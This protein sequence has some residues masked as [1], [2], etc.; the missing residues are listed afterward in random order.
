MIVV[1]DVFQLKFGHAREAVEVWKEGIKLAQE[2]GYGAKDHRL[3]TDFVGGSYYTLVFETRFESLA[4]FEQAIQSTL[5][6][7]R[8]R[9]WYQKL[10]PHVDSGK[11][12]ILREV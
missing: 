12:E 11:R 10:L 4:E 1:R 9:E 5:G 6:N 7:D 3:M 8:W 2:T